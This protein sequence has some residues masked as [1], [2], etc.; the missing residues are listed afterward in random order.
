MQLS[1]LT[2]K[3]V[4]A[5]LSLGMFVMGFGGFFL[6][7][8]PLAQAQGLHGI[9]FVKGC[10]SPTD[11]GSPYLCTYA[12][13]NT[14]DTGNGAGTSDT[15]TITSVVDVV[16][17][18]PSDVASANLLPLLTLHLSGG[19]TCNVGQT[20]CTLPPGSSITSDPYSFYTPDGND[21][22]PLTDT[23]TLTWQDLCTSNADNCPATAQTSTSG[24]Q[25]TLQ[26]LNSTVATQ[27]HNTSHT[28]ITGTSAPV[29]TVV[30]D[31][32]TVTGSL[33][34][35][36]GTVTFVRFSD[37][38]CT[39]TSSTQSGLALTAGVVE[40][41]TTS[42]TSTGLSYRASY[43]GDSV[44]NPSVGIC[45]TLNGTKL[46][47]T[48]VTQVLNASSTDVTNG[49]VLQGTTVHDTV[50]VSGS[51]P[52]PTGTVD[53]NFFANGT[54]T[55]TPDSLEAGIALSGG[56]AQASPITPSAGSYSYL[57][58]YNGDNVYTAG[59]AACEPFSVEAPAPPPPPQQFPT[60]TL[61]F[62]QTHTDF[63]S[64]VF[65]SISPITLGGMTIDTTGKLFG[66]FYASIPKT[67]TGA[68]RTPLDQARMQLAQ[69][70]LAAVLN[71]AY[72]GCS[73]ETQALIAKAS[74]DFSSTNITEILADA[75]AL[76]GYNN[77]GDSL[78][79]ANA[80]AATPSIS[81]TLANFGFWNV[82]N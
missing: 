19:A 63:T 68:K 75:A 17:A 71:C 72:F 23:A 25:S 39:A 49:T 40:S 13:L 61:G 14:V 74:A 77:S 9:G 55:G 54:C 43:S 47:P 12:I 80:G 65:A 78:G 50:T 21:P 3:A 28:D 70:Y 81:K 6:G 62:W 27:I 69:Q 8:A 58:H 7:S 37:P 53:F 34:T 64:S 67:T 48:V 26:K 45:E 20:L 76:D 10:Q 18:S 32:A 33:G 66:G 2:K 44:Y 30:H 38:N 22:S 73:A 36:T 52:T 5:G 16:H 46:T 41:A 42:L 15:L 35:P 51:G 4:S 24:S 79:T 11:I 29:G 1:T 59:V 31:Q 56:T 82:L 57:V 60:R